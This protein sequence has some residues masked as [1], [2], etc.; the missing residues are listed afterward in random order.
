MLE[1]RNEVYESFE[2]MRHEFL[3]LILK[4]S[5]T[6]NIDEVDWFLPTQVPKRWLSRNPADIE[7]LVKLDRSHF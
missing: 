4:S 2:E 1:K 5:I 6:K 7:Y 3:K